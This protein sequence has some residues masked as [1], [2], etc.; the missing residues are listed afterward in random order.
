MKFIVT[1]PGTL[2][3]ITYLLANIHWSKIDGKSSMS[4]IYQ[5]FLKESEGEVWTQSFVVCKR[6]N[7]VIL[8]CHHWN[9]SHT[10]WKSLK[11]FLFYSQRWIITFLWWFFKTFYSKKWILKVI[12]YSL[13][14]FKRS[15]DFKTCL[16]N[17][18]YFFS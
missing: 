13:I 4:P 10:S 3:N 12:E 15:S 16:G 17:W 1:F 2:Y 7:C 9:K 14:Y 18:K 6:S 5:S 8:I 11:N